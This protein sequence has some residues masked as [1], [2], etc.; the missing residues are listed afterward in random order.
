VK[1]ANL[2][3]KV[4]PFTGL[5]R[6]FGLNVLLLCEA[7]NRSYDKENL[8]ACDERECKRRKREKPPEGDAIIFG[9]R[10]SLKKK[11]S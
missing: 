1:L 7:K 3:V 2:F 9:C 8:Q 5:I 10:S 11:K 6:P 4:A